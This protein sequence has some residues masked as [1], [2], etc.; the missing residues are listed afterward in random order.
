MDFNQFIQAA[1]HK[2]VGINAER[3]AFHAFVY[4][5]ESVERDELTIDEWW[6][7]WDKF[8]EFFSY[9]DEAATQAAALV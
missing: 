1:A 4:G 5:D 6:W 3:E 8:C 2:G 7:Y 9:D